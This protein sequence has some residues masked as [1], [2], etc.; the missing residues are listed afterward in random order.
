MTHVLG[1]KPVGISFY[2]KKPP[3]LTSADSA[4][5]Y[6]PLKAIRE[7]EEKERNVRQK[8][9]KKWTEEGDDHRVRC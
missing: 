4:S 1:M 6:E 7:R 9:Y 2:L 3:G 8:V 5:F